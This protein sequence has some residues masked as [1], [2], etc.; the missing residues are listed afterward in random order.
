MEGVSSIKHSQTE[1]SRLQ[2]ARAVWPPWVCPTN[3]R[4]FNIRKIS[5]RHSPRSQVQVEKSRLQNVPPPPWGQSPCPQ[6]L[7]PRCLP[8]V[9][10]ISS[11]RPLPLPVGTSLTGQPP[12]LESPLRHVAIWVAGPPPGLQTPLTPHRLCLL[13]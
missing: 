5:D 10:A 7:R 4:V 9:D 12:F 6:R 3:A 11:P 8:L 2:K 13:Y 1:H